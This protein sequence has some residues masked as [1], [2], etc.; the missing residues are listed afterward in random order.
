M[1]ASVRNCKILLSSLCID[2]GFM[3]IVTVTVLMTDLHPIV[4]KETPEE[5]SNATKALALRWIRL[6]RLIFELLIKI[7]T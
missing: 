6:A 5:M 7:C 3:D 2:V 1:T 4:E